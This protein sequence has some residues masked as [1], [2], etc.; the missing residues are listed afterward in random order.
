MRFRPAV[1]IDAASNL[2]AT[3]LAYPLAIWLRSYSAMLFVLLLQ[4]AAWSLSSHLVAERRYSLSWD[5][6]YGK[7]M[8]TF[9]WPLLING[10]FLYG[11]M[12][13]D[14]V[15][16]GS[17]KQLFAGSTYTLTDLGIYSVAFSLTMAPT[18]F[19]ATI[20]TSL[21]LPV[22]ASAKRAT[23][24]FERRYLS[25]F[26]AVCLSAALISVPFIFSGGQVL[27]WVY[28]VKY[29]AGGAIVG[30][31][32]A[33]WGVRIIRTAPT[34][35][36]LAYADTKAVML[37][38]IIRSVALVGILFA[39]A[40]GAS[41]IWVA[42]SG[43]VGELLALPALMWRISR[44]NGVRAKPCLRPLFVLGFAMAVAGAASTSHP[45]GLGA[46]GL[47]FCTLLMA[48]LTL[49]AMIWAIPRM[50]H[51]LRAVVASLS[52]ELRTR[53]INAGAPHCGQGVQL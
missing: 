45:A 25:T 29:S 28:G 16:I 1:G 48:T 12:Q 42:I 5:W 37:S 9:G 22:L 30:C 17:S 15:L 8:F 10:L 41:L 6:R 47:A 3:V 31:L 33:M 34:L 21:F 7:R 44:L 24:D 38:N 50:R 20:A 11:I 14:R 35:A 40:T 32:A 19:V 4:A 26:D 46:F 18:M 43:L 51:D 52:A 13:G 53:V 27:V 2:F 36:A 23:A 39:A 49:C